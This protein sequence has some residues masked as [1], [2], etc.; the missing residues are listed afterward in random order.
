[1]AVGQRQRPAV[2]GPVGVLDPGDGAGG[3]ERQRGG[4]VERLTHGEVDGDDTRRRARRARSGGG[5]RGARDGDAANTARTVSLNWRMLRKPA[6]KAIAVNGRSDV[7]MSTRAVV[8]RWARAMASGPAPSS[9]VI[10]RLRWRS[11]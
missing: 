10:T 5:R 2:A 9:S 3:E 6:A 8:A 4:E 11:L 1:M 7:S